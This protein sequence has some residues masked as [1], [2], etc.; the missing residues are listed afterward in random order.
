MRLQWQ[1][2]KSGMFFVLGMKDVRAYLL[3]GARILEQTRP[4]WWGPL[5][6]SV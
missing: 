1:Q 2:T 4:N 3:E 5:R 6:T